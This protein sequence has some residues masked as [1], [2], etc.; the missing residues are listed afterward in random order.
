MNERRLSSEHYMFATLPWAKWL[1]TLGDMIASGLVVSGTKAHRGLS[2][3]AIY[4]S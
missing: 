2:R 3:L 1:L 4:C